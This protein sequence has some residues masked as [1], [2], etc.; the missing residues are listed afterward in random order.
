MSEDSQRK[1]RV[2]WTSEEQTQ[3]VE[4]AVRLSLGDTD[5]I[6]SFIADGQKVL[7]PERQ[8]MIAGRNGIN[9]KIAEEFCT[10]RQGILERGVPFQVNIEKQVN[11]ERP[12]AEILAS[13][14]TQELIQLVADRMAPIIELL[15]V[16]LQKG[17]E[18]PAK[19][20]PAESKREQSV[21][22]IPVPT[23]PRK[24]RVLMV[25][26][27]P[28]QE[29]IFEEKVKNFNLELKFLDKDASKPKVP[30]SCQ[31]CISLDKIR[32][33][34]SDKLQ[35]SFQKNVFFVKGLDGALKQLADLNS[36]VGYDAG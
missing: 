11:I 15:P 34:V 36:R 2:V 35:D 28:G 17:I 24:P 13:I 31:W 25:G 7:P 32:H 20:A 21:I 29:K 23:G 16:F 33:A 8:R 9:T 1:T 30:P 3:V 14:T 4:E 22:P 18:Q 10:Q 12:R 19:R 26:F 6:W 5:Y 27:L